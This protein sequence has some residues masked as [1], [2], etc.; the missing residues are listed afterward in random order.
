MIRLVAV[1]ALIL[2]LASAAHA[3]TVTSYTLTIYAAGT[4]TLIGT[5]TAIPAAS[6]VC[7]QPMPTGVTVNPNKVV[8]VDP[9]NAGQACIYTDA[10]AGPLSTLPFGGASYEATVSA[11][12]SVG[13]SAES[14]RAL[15]FTHPGALPSVPTGV[16]V[17]R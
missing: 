13:S 11:T 17:I 10:G 15:P 4:S 3:Q 9:G 7:N 2:A 16:K 8:F 14:A 1:L 12:N 5:P 6:F